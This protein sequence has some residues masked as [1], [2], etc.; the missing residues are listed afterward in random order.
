MPC[1]YTEVA[2]ELNL[3]DKPWFTPATLNDVVWRGSLLAS[4]KFSA[5]VSFLI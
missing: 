4:W 1:V 2:V 3:A 5:L